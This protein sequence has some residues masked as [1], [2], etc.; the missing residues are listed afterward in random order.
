MN[1]AM[2]TKLIKA[3]ITGVIICGALAF[4]SMPTT[5]LGQAIDPCKALG[6]CA[7][8][9]ENYGT[10]D[11]KTN[12]VKVISDIISLL[13]YVSAAISVLFIVLGGYQMITSSGD[14]EKV[15][16]GKETF[17]YA[18]I[19]LIAAIIA[20]FVVS[21]ITQILQGNLLGS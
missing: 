17:T 15:K 5:A 10:G 3:L 16:K 2:R 12:I 6:G 1:Y 21:V 14:A 18:I 7:V 19:G 20:G 4:F 8:G 11:T 13:V 9:T